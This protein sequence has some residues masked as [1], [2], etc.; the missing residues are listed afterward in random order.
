MRAPV[1][2]AYNWVVYMYL[3]II[4]DRERRIM[5]DANAAWDADL[6]GPAPDN[7]VFGDAHTHL[8]Q[9]GPADWPGIL[10]R[11]DA[12]GIGF[13]VCAGTTL[14]TTRDCIRMTAEYPQFYAGVGIHP[15]EA[16]QPIDAAA[17]AEWLSE[18][19]G[20]VYRLPS[21][22]EWE[23]AARAGAATNFSWG[24]A[25]DADQANCNG[26]GSQWDNDRPAPVGSF[27]ANPWGLH[28]MHGNVWEW[29]LDCH[30]EDY[31]GAAADGE[32]YTDGDCARRIL[33]GG[34]WSSSPAVIRAAAREWDNA[35]VRTTTTGFRLAA[36]VN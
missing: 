12:A 23:Y 27:A 29:A 16:H 7:F 1:D 14:E 32:A 26:C 24:D 17:Y 35:S 25:V 6:Y 36:A 10:Q 21:E 8:N 9:Y 3:P 19:T 31:R 34:S 15:M 5:T 28:D 4:S 33:R 2:A 20:R 18:E 11:A 13:I 30:S 22:A